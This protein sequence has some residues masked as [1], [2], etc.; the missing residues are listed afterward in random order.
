MTFSFIKPKKN[1]IEKSKTNK[2]VLKRLQIF[3]DDNI[4]EPVEIL[5]R[6]WKDQKNAIT[7]KEIR[8]AILKGDL[9]EEIFQLWQQDYAVLVA[10]KLES[11]WNNAMLVGTRGQPIL[12]K[13]ASIFYYDI[14]SPRVRDWIATRGAEFITAITTEQKAAIRALIKEYTKGG[15]T[16]DELSRVIRPCIGLTKQQSIANL[17]YY[18]HIKETLSQQHPRMKIETAQKKAREAALKYAE[19]QHRDRAYTIAQ[20]ETAFAYNK[21]ADE[22]I[23]QA[24]EENL[25]GIVE[26]RWCTSGDRNVCDICQSLDG[27][28]IELDSDFDFKGKELYSGQKQTPPAHP[29]CGCAIEYIEIISTK[30]Y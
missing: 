15:Y 23:R 18:N 26:K 8:E 4:D 30:I 21:G 12:D 9:T 11:I 1:I 10:T 14:T 6:H 13:L 17:R 7:Y 2:E 28:Q 25:L 27:M 29:R 19:K 20:T 3:L 22:A 5:V 16:V 24:Q